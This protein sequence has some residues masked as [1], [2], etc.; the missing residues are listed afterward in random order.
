MSSAFHQ[1]TKTTFRWE[2]DRDGGEHGVATYFL[3]THRQVQLRI[4]S[5]R[6]ANALAMAIDWYAK[7]VR[8]SARAEL[9]AE[10]GRIKP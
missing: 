8:E 4:D 7:N 10:I 2:Q 5:F 9:L 3:E 6:E 1:S